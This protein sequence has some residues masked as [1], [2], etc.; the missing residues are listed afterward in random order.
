MLICSYGKMKKVL[1]KQNTQ[2]A[3]QLYFQDALKDDAEAF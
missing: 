1:L 3:F 2:D